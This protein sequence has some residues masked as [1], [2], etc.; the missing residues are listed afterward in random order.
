[1]ESV[2]SPNVLESTANGLMTTGNPLDLPSGSE[3]FDQPIHNGEAASNNYDD[4]F[5]VLPVTAIPH[6]MDSNLGRWNEK[7]RVGVRNV[8]QVFHIPGCERKLDEKFGESDLQKRCVDIMMATGAQ[9]ECSSARDFSLTFIVVGKP[10]AVL[11]A[12]R[13]ILTHFQTQANAAVT[14]PKEHH[15]YILGK[16][17]QKLQELETLT[18]TKITVPKMTD[19]SDSITMTGTKEGIEKAIHEIRLISDEQSKQAYERLEIPK[20]YH[21]FIAGANNEKVK[22]LMETTGARINIPP[23]SVMKDELTI[24]GEKE[25]VLRAKDVIMKQFEE[26]K[27]KC[28]TVSVEVKKSQH[29]Y[30]IGA[31][32][33][34]IAEIL[35]ETGVS[36]EMPPSDTVTETITLRGPHDKLPIALSKVYE[37]ANS[38][39]S[40]DVDAPS[41]IHRHIIGKKGAGIRAITQD[42]PKV[43][44]ELTDK[45]DKIQIEGPTEDVEKVAD[46]LHEEV[47]RLLSSMTYS[48]VPIDGKYHKHIIG[49]GGVNINRIK[50]ETGVTINFPENETTNIIRIEGPPEGVQKAKEE[51]VAMSQKMENERERDI[52][53]EN[54]FHKT[55]IGAKGEKIREIRE[56]FNQVQIS[57]P[58]PS[59]KRDVVKIRGPKADVESCFN[60]LKKLHKELLETSYSVKVPIFKEF[61]K[62]VIGKGGANI[63]KIREETKTRIDLPPEG[64]D[65]DMV[66]ITGRKEDVDKA[67]ERI[68]KI[69]SELVT[70]VTEEV[71]I[72][73]RYHNFIIGAGGKLIQ[74]IMDEC[75]GVQIKFPPSE[76]NS[77][78]V[79]L[80]GPKEEVAKAKKTLLELSQE[81][82]ISDY[83]ETVKAKPEHHRFL[84][85]RNGANI[86]KIR[87]N[88]GAR[89]VFP[90]D[91]DADRSLIT[92]IGK[93]ESVQKART[94]LE[95]KIKELES[96][97]EDEMKVEPR[98]HRHFVARRGEVLQD[99]AEQFGGVSISFPR[100][101]V[102]SD[103]VVIK[104]AKECVAQAKQR[105]K[106]I[107]EDLEHQVT[108]DCVIPQQYHRTVMGAKGSKVQAITAEHN[109]NIKFPDRDTNGN[110]EMNPANPESGEELTEPRKEDTIKIS[111]HSDNCEGAKQA[112]LALVPISAEVNVPYEYHRYIIGQ[113]GRDVRQMMQTYDVSIKIPNAESHS[114]VIV[115]SGTLACVEEA[116][117]ALAEKIEILEKEKED[118]I[119]KSYSV[120]VDVP[121]EYHSKIIGRGG[122]T[123]NNLRHEFDV[124]IQFPR[125]GDENQFEVTIS[126][127][128]K[129]VN[130]CKEKILAMVA[131]L[132]EMVKQELSIDYRIHSRMIGRGGRGIKKIMDEYGVEVRFPGD[133]ND[134]NL[135]IIIG[136]EKNV[137]DCADYLL[138][139]AEEFLQD[140]LEDENSRQ[141]V[142]E[143]PREN[144]H[145]HRG[146]GPGFIVSGAPWQHPG[147]RSQSAAFNNTLEDFPSIGEMKATNAPTWGPRR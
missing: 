5:P 129:D 28:A 44:V 37:K 60:Y 13:E 101:G 51:L 40:V 94:E 59:E 103:R 77:D 67:R 6:G 130:Q 88:T 135:V 17:G 107:V 7:L 34:G 36:I 115:I 29:K 74:S 9:I 12:R 89:I 66:I 123:I 96:T 120:T 64:S 73:S 134:K 54:R 26:L 140:F 116:K 131:E 46:A 119:L 100:P 22:A 30:V 24:A 117:Q 70:M 43:H 68:M 78:K 144:R 110:G 147:G 45:T 139:M 39:T 3:A 132:D 8:T 33:S 127:Y 48:D 106:E 80:R 142:R 79:T 25:G 138:N 109:V 2:L 10:D 55:I 108:I 18:A 87:E 105:I 141:Y 56:K 14:I 57:F 1:M 98:H 27:R 146:E 63:K 114:D 16:G 65:S 112:L 20:V 85:G 118:R 21:P 62:N 52:I 35:Q 82:N 121:P 11:K 69:Q 111:G 75:G 83:Q 42:F 19:Q 58:D 47:N 61:H 90:G 32:G 92:I 84:I 97:T 99:L 122:A 4:I 81:R 15:K 53:I 104:G 128:E 143:S 76:A 31:R 38:V 133:E 102:D 95:L 91:E 126:G 93:K 125:R 124:V 145:Q 23:L 137:S 71:S 50:E 41:W 86:R 49:K 136:P 113:K 72:P